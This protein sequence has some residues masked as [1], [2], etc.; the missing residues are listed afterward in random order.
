MAL[1]K[2]LP[3][4]V[5]NGEWFLTASGSDHY[6]FTGS[7]LDAATNDPTLYLTKGQF[8]KFNNETSGTSHPFK[9]QSTAGTSGTAYNTGVT[10][11]GGGNGLITFEVPLDAPDKLYYQCTDH[12]NMNGVI[13]TGTGEITNDNISA[14]ANIATSKIAGLA[15]SATTD[16]TNASNISSGTVATARLGSGTADNTKFLRGDGSWQ[17]VSIPTLDAPV[18]TGDLTV[19][20]TGTSRTH[21]ITNWSDAVSYTRVPTNCTLGSINTSGEFT[22]THTSGTPS[23][24]IKA[25]TDSL[26]LGDSTVVT[27]TFTSYK[28]SAPTL[29]SPANP[30]I[31]TNF[32]YTIT[33]TDSADDKLILDLGSSNFT[34]VSVSA[35]SGSKVG[36]T[37]ELT[38]FTTN[39]PVVTLK[40]TAAATYSVKA[41]A[42]KA[43]GSIT[44]SDY[45][46][47]DSI[48]CVDPPYAVDFLVIAGGGSGNDGMAGGMGGGG[49]GGYRNSYASET[50]GG[51]SPTES[52][53]TL[54]PGTVYTIT[55]GEGGT[56]PNSIH[57]PSDP[58]GNSSIVGSD[59]TDIVSTGGGGGGVYNAGASNGGSGGG[60]SKYWPSSGTGP[61][62]SGTSGQGF[63]GETSNNQW[64]AGGGGGGG[65][66]GE[67][68]GSDGAGYGGDG[69]SSSI[70]GTAVMRGGGGGGS[71]DPNTTQD[72]GSGG[73]GN[74][75]N[76]TGGHG[77]ANTGGG[78]GSGGNS[79]GNG[80]SG[81]VILRMATSNYSGTQSGGTVTT[82]GSDTIISYTTV[83]SNHTYT[84]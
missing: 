55:V 35:G 28:L 18:I 36:N 68:G 57:T 2:A 51:N 37:I 61:A 52:D 83:A 16:T 26:G 58:G 54:T 21:T 3:L 64:S 13:Y 14:S 82:D 59:I 8:Y 7:G 27:K 84:A 75:T 4:Q 39:N 5:V 65:G 73:G 45:S 32:T 48:T 25:T 40:F 22:V 17:V 71:S 47:V 44:E 34:Y 70:T 49:A 9:I 30:N 79:G 67:A 50:S 56:S 74:G 81:I 31:N 78:G 19:E 63:G 20:G 23:Y 46:A 11:N 66:A 42:Q 43:D 53:L 77:T 6:V 38:G 29:N 33:S 24:T 69:L 80:G 15:A 1:T 72:G 60:G 10:N 62:G 76:S 12:A 41:K